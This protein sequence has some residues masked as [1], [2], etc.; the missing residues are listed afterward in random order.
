MRKKKS[1]C[2]F[3]LNLKG[4]VFDRRKKTPRRG[5]MTLKW[6][7]K[8]SDRRRHRFTILRKLQT[9]SAASREKKGKRRGHR[10]SFPHGGVTPEEKSASHEIS[11]LKAI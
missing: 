4:R 5:R 1:V 11:T 2:R 7:E 9:G 6:V 8:V 3:I 10:E